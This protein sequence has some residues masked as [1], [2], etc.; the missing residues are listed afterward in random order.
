MK[1]RL[2]TATIGVLL[3]AFLLLRGTMS[4]MAKPLASPRSQ[5]GQR[6]PAASLPQM[7]QA[8]ASGETFTVTSNSDASDSNPGDCICKTSGNVCTLRAAIQEA[9][10]C[11]GWQVI[12]FAHPM[13][14]QP[15]SQ[16]DTLTDDKTDINAL[17]QMVPAF[18]TTRPGVILDG[19]NS[20]SNGFVIHG[21]RNLIRGL[22]IMRFSHYGIML[23]S[24]AQHNAINNNVVSANGQNGIYLHGTN[25]SYNNII[26]NKVGTNPI[27]SGTSFGGISNWG[28]GHHGI[29]VWDGKENNVNNNLVADNGWSGITFDNVKKG[30]IG[31]NII[32]VTFDRKPLGNHA[33]GVHIGNGATDMVIAYN[34]IG[35][36]RRGI[37][38]TGNSRAT[39]EHNFIFSNTTSSQ[40]GGGIM[41]DSNS[42]VIIRYNNIF[43]NTATSGGGIAIAGLSSVG[44]YTNTIERNHAYKTTSGGS[45]D[46]GG[47]S[48]DHAQFAWL[49]NNR[50]LSNTVTG[51]FTNHPSTKGGGVS[52]YRVTSGFVYSCEI[53]GNSVRGN[54]GGGGGILS[55]FGKHIFISNN[56][57]INNSTN[58]ASYDGS[59]ID[60]VHTD[61]T[62]SLT[63]EKNW[64]EGNHGGD[65]AIFVFNS[66]RILIENNVIVNNSYTG[67]S[68]RSN[69]SPLTMTHNTIVNNTYGI[70]LK[71]TN[72]VLANSIVVSNHM[73]GIYF[74][75]SSASVPI[76]EHNDVWGNTNGG[77]NKPM[78][79][80]QTQDPLFFDMPAKQYELRNGS[81]CIDT[82]STTYTSFKSYT[83]LKRPQGAG[84]DIGAYEMLHEFIPLIER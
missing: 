66:N 48:A 10:V 11:S 9:N 5:F 23:E 47:V 37:Y 64:V 79:F 63:I 16:L 50:I 67:V 41:A 51:V 13:T 33:Y 70:T 45:I 46:G 80:F 19:N 2:A 31:T 60:I 84:P 75:D 17:D 62:G 39:I 25:T 53:R 42:T 22:T 24:G 35:N 8:P 6:M 77:S 40:K 78:S 61:N 30:T 28:N 73:Y 14:I 52:F 38:I 21:S 72:L 69:T 32:G 83:D 65:G 4:I 12:K 49:I 36:N 59:G 20:I 71:S 82:G 27:G 57:I 68:F 56:K 58:T 1:K 74:V 81:P 7:N 15:L 3:T 54:N 29:S 43:R 44:V 26:H 55:F 76:S 18:G 34:Q